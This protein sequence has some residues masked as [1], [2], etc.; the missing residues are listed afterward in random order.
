MPSFRWF[1]FKVNNLIAFL[2]IAMFLVIIYE[3]NSLMANFQE[4]S[5]AKFKVHPHHEII[6]PFDRSRSRPILKPYILGN[7]EN[8]GK[9]QS[10]EVP[11]LGAGGVK[12]ELGPEHKSLVDASV[13]EYGFNIHLSDMISLDRTIKD[14]RPDQCK[15]WHYQDV[16]ELPTATVVLVYFNEA[17]SVI[18]RTLHSVINTSP[19]ELMREVILVDDGSTYALHKNLTAY[20]HQRFPGIVKTMRNEARLGLIHARMQGAKMATSD[21]V[22]VLD[23]HCECVRNWLPPLLSEIALD[24]KT[25]AIP[26][27][28]GITWDTLEHRTVYNPEKRHTGIWEWGFLYKETVIPQE[29]EAKHKEVSEPYWSPT[30]AGGLLAIDRSW[31]FELGGYDDEMKIWGGE[32]YELSFKVW[33]CGGAVK[34]VPC[35]HVGHIY[36][37]PRKRSFPNP[38]GKSHQT[39]RNHLRLSAIWM[40][41]Y[42]KY[43]RIREPAT[44]R[45]TFGSIRG[46]LELRSRLKCKSFEWFMQTV[47]Y[48]VLEKFPV[49]PDN[50][51]WGTLRNQQHDVCVDELGASY[52][53]NIGVH[54]CNSQLFRLNVVGELSSGEHCFKAVDT[55]VMNVHCVSDGTWIPKGEWSYSTLNETLASNGK[56]METDGNKLFMSQCDEQKKSQKWTWAEF[57]YQ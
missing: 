6:Q 20:A 14:T 41:E 29:E 18:A 43:F 49:P 52:G 37:G 32:Q 5:H 8:A 47:A 11:S 19:P 2:S 9:L 21:V 51:K 23:A 4:R 3:R 36:R 15:F 54:P 28:D 34:W 48:K 50:L 16:S 46:Q 10:V 1:R 24:R 42:Q 35:S 55:G 56:C 22:V 26:I 27:V 45:L 38:N 53:S 31:F 17:W 12:V 25:V 33:M 30:H 40:D 7:Y 13:D 57:Y 39:D 44:T